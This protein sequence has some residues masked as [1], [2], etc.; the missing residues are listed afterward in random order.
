M[1]YIAETK[2]RSLIHENNGTVETSSDN[3]NDLS[4]LGKKIRRP[5]Q[6]LVCKI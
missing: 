2:S 5:D 6:A 1:K 3:V 4:D